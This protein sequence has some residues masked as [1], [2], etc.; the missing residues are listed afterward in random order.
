MMSLSIQMTTAQIYGLFFLLGTFAV[1]SLSDLKRL[2]AQREFFEIWIGFVAVMLLYDVYTK[3]GLSILALKWILIAA[4]AVL[5]S[6]RIGKIFSLARADVT[7][8]S[9]AAALLNP[10]YIVIYYIILWITDK[11]MGP[12]ISR[13]FGIKKKKGAEYPFLPIVLAATIIVLLIGI[14]GIFE[15]IASMII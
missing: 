15:K 3:T 12:V 8:I 14:S 9:A 10:F 6:Q 1:A 11:I 7:A 2:S 5:S 4:F 13:I